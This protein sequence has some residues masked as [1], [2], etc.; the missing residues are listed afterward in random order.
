[1]VNYYAYNSRRRKDQDWE[2]TQTDDGI[3]ANAELCAGMAVDFESQ[4]MR[5]GFENRAVRSGQTPVDPDGRGP[6]RTRGLNKILRD[7]S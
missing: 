2:T 3:C 7:L 4:E 1:M 6:R 5:S